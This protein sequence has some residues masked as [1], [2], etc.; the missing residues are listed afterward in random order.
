MTDWVTISALA[1]AGGTL[2]LAVATFQ[3]V[4]S[5]NRSARIAE[6]SLLEGVRPVLIPSREDDASQRIRFGD[7]VI[8]T[9][10][11]HGAAAKAKHEVAYLAMALR[12]GGAGLAVIHGWR[13]RAAPDSRPTVDP[14]R[15][16]EPIDTDQF[17]AQR[18]PDISEF[19]RQQLDLYVPAGETGYWQGAMRTATEPGHD[20]VM[21]ALGEDRNLWI[22]L[23]YG[24]YDGGQ[25]T[26]VRFLLGGWGEDGSRRVS[27]LRYWNVDRDD[28]R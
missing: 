4:Q 6:R 5:A 8:L 25:R 9:V 27:V 7:D 26:I 16:G 18:R 10:P 1:T 17:P 3:S 11:G 13:A 19:R 21:A 20:E 22:D 2:V 23:L 24:D 15:V 28:P 14:V 12:N